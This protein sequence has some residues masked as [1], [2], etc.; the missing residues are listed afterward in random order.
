MSLVLLEIAD[1]VA[2]ITLNNPDERNTMTAPMV[3]EIVAA[4]DRIENDP[5]I[6]AL[7]VTGTAPAFCA[8]A[9]LGNL[10]E[11]DGE[12]L[13]VIYEG[14]L[15]IARSPLPTIAAVNGAAV[16]AGMNLALVATCALQR[17]AQSLTHAFCNWVFTQVVDTR[18]CCVELLDHKL[19]RLPYCSVKFTMAQKPNVLD[20]HTSV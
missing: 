18:G 15:R 17:V 3:A 13:G 5:A 1:G 8:G 4:M 16:G 2:T 12:S 20:L 14:F 6:G 11:A 10:A 9:N 7:V 19:H